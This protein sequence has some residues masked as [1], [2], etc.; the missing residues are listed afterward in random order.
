M[1]K[2]EWRLLWPFLLFCLCN[3]TILLAS[4]LGKPDNA[5]KVAG[6]KFIRELY[7]NGNVKYEGYIENGLREGYWKFFYEDG[8][9]RKHG[10]YANGTK[11]HWWEEFYFNGRI[12]SEGLYING[13]KNHFWTF[14]DENGLKRLY[15]RYEKGKRIGIWKSYKNGIFS[16]EITYPD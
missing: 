15:G 6:K 8:S 10:E 3:M 16:V 7:L 11:S 9:I 5:N 12:K 13:V 1:V 2:Y 14:Y 4:G